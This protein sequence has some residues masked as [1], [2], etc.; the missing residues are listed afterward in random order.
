MKESRERAL[1]RGDGLL[2]SWFN[3]GI[4]YLEM[5][6]EDENKIGCVFDYIR[7]SS[8]S[9]EL[10]KETKAIIAYIKKTAKKE[11]IEDLSEI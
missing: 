8:N 11:K 4:S 1:D 9:T 7:C 3:A 2:A 6:V 5:M 10:K